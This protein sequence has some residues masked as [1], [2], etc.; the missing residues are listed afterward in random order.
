[1]MLLFAL[2]LFGQSVPG[3]RQMRFTDAQHGI[4]FT[5]P[6]GYMLKTGPLGPND[7]GLG[8]LGPIPMEF[9]APGGQ[10]I[11]TVEAPR[12]SYP[13]TDFVNAFFTVSVNRYLSRDEC[14][15]FPN[16]QDKSPTFL[17]KTERGLV[18]H[19][20]EQS[21][22]GMGHEFMGAYYHTF[23]YGQCTELGYGIATAGLG[24]VDGMRQA[25]YRSIE[26][27]FKAILLSVAIS[28]PKNRRDRAHHP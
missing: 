16:L 6:R 4:S 15:R 12:G 5:Y 13:G 14:V 19:G 21:D 22:G 3:Q 18:F 9:T 7:M 8:Y 10:R 25:P 27:R 23:S 28:K 2:L 1:M 24:A 26:S 11:A 20:V 17:M